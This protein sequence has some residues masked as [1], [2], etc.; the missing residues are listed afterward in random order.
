MFLSRFA[1]VGLCFLVLVAIAMQMLFIN[2][3]IGEITELAS[4]ASLSKENARVFIYEA[5]F[6]RIGAYCGILLFLSLMFVDC[7]NRYIVGILG[8]L[9]QLGAITAL[10]AHSIDAFGFNTAIYLSVLVSLAGTILMLTS[11]TLK[12]IP[13]SNT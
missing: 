11:I 2:G 12:P 3:H 6:W 9:I 10:Q 1:K 13:F 4:Y 7:R 8:G 5:Q